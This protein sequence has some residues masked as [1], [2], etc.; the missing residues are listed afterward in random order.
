MSFLKIGDIKIGEGMPKICVPIVGMTEEEILL[1]TEEVYRSSADLAEW[2]VDW[3]E[4]A[5]DIEKVLCV[6][7][8]IKELL[9]EKPLIFTFRTKTE[10]GEKECS[11]EQY[12]ELL[13]EVAKSKMATVID[14]E[15]L[16]W[17]GI[18]ALIQEIQREQIPV[19]GSNHD[20]LKTESKV[21]L[22]E[23]MVMI[24]NMGVD[25]VKLAVMPRN[26]ED[27][28]ILLEATLEMRKRHATVPIVTMSMSKTGAIS[29]IS[30]EMFGSAITFASLG[31]MSAP[32]QIEVGKMQGVLK[33]LHEM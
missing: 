2:R 12:R 14:V 13:I 22:I 11:Y 15:V 9:R 32:G 25:V 16:H 31:R 5:L 17:E 10:G 21:E 19:I 24:Q 3:F 28:L 18:K 30:G 33:I 1:Q 6:L 20:F 29:R 23:R 27:V 8:K 7:E 26:E 4:D